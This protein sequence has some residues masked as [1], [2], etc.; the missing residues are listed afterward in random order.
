MKYASKPS[1]FTSHKHGTKQNQPKA[2]ISL[3]KLLLSKESPSAR[4]SLLLTDVSPKE[5]PTKSRKEENHSYS[6]RDPFLRSSMG[7]G[8]FIYG[9]KCLL[10]ILR[11]HG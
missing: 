3:S 4:T 6:P 10:I 8:S 5:Q 2:S 1:T 11:S 7:T 9:Q